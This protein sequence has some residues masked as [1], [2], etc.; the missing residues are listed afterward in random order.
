MKIQDLI[1]FKGNNRTFYLIVGLI[2]LGT[3]AWLHRETD[4][5]R[6]TGERIADEQDVS[7][8]LSDMNAEG[9]IDVGPGDFAEL[10][11]QEEDLIIIDVRTPGE[12]QDGKVDE[13]L[14]I[15]L[16]GS[17]FHD[18]IRALDP[19]TPYLVYCN[20]GNRS[21]QASQIM[22]D[23]GFSRVYNYDGCHTEIR[24]EYRQWVME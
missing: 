3:A 21:R 11:Q 8:R 6:I 20:S 2:L 17:S 14:T 13:A 23:E 12:W 22:I 16:N 5:P 15:N 9:F 4:S 19:D 10:R 18:E 7:G 1:P 24:N